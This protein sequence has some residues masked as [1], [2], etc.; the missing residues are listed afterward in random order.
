MYSTILGA[1]IKC[2]QYSDITVE[3]GTH[4]KSVKITLNIF[5][6]QLQLKLW[7]ETK[8]FLYIIIYCLDA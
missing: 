4:V 6:V 3:S 1:I 2:K 8:I 5:A 7:V